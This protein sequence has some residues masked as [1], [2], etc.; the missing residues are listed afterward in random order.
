MRIPASP[1]WI[2]DQTGRTIIIT[3]ADS[4]IGRAAAAAL[5]AKGARLILA[6]RDQDKGHA[7]AAEMSGAVE[8]RPL[9]LASLESIRDFA[10]GIDS[11]VD[12]LVNNAGTM[13]DSLRHTTEGFELQFGVHHL[14]HFALTNLLLDR[15]TSRVVTVSS[16]AHRIAHID[17][18]GLQWEERPYKPLLVHGQSK[19]ANLLFTVEL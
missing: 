15:V 11:A 12:I 17:F 1:A 9:D 8:V 16:D 18:D 13:T 10:A 4:G 5:V 6:V 19:P 7:A 3:G 14:G 2:P